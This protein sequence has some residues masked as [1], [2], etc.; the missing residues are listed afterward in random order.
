MGEC[1]WGL[2]SLLKWDKGTLIL[3]SHVELLDFCASGELSFSTQN[4]KRLMCSSTIH[5]MVNK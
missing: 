2:D 3:F 1:M 5:N 4:W